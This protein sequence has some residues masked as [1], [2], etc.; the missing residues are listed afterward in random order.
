M[1]ARRDMYAEQKRDRDAL[2]QAQATELN[3]H[4]AWAKELYANARQK[5]FEQVKE[6]TA[7]EWEAVRSIADKDTRE[8]GASALKLEQS[9]LYA[10]TAAE[11]VAEARTGKN[12]A[13]EALRDKHVEERAEL[14]GA[15]R[16]ETTSAIR[17][18]TAERLGVQQQERARHLQHDAN[19][20]A[21]KTS[22]NQGM[23]NQ[24]KA[25]I[26]AMHL[27]QRAGGQAATTAQ[28]APAEAAKAYMQTAHAEHGKRESIRERLIAQRQGN[29]L[30]ASTP[31]RSGAEANKAMDAPSR[32]SDNQQNAARQAAQS[33]RTLTDAERV[34]APQDV[35]DRLAHEDRKS[36][37]RSEIMTS[38]T[39]AQQQRGKGREGGGRGR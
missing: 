21:A 35:K 23:A 39:N 3:Q 9:K 26:Q 27:K 15:H 24:Q 22:G 29:H 11:R 32:A 31:G 2:R 14:R 20:I 5:A 12:L 38:I 19:R 7:A 1:Q 28:M 30:R 37:N 8:Q 33:G 4:K 16:D 36:A 6:Q 18:H 13:W 34:N 17:Q 25:A 10:A